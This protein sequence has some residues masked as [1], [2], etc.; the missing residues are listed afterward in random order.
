MEARRGDADDQIPDDHAMRTQHLVA[1]DDADRKP[2]QVQM[3]CRDDPG[4]LAGL[5][6]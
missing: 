3:I 2:G 6:R 1:L 4:V 5:L